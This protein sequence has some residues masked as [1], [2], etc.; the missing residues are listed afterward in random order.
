MKAFSKSDKLKKIIA[1][2]ITDLI[3]FLDNNVKLAVFA[4][5]NIYLLY[6]YLEIIG[7]PATLNTSRQHSRHFF[8]SSST[9]IDTET[10]QPVIASLHI[11]QNIIWEFYGTIGHEVDD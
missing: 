3:T 2:K 9:N 7:S 4:G 5:G 11:L 8:P 10:L 6:C 1:S